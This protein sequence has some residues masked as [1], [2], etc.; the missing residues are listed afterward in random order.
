MQLRTRRKR[1]AHLW[2]TIGGV[3][4]FEQWCQWLTN[5]SW[6][7]KDVA[8]E[9]GHSPSFRI[10]VFGNASTGVKFCKHTLGSCSQ[11]LC[12]Y[13]NRST[14]TKVDTVCA[15]HTQHVGVHQPPPQSKWTLV[16]SP[17]WI[18][19]FSC[20]KRN[21]LWAWTCHWNTKKVLLI[22]H[23]LLIWQGN[24]SGSNG[25]LNIV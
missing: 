17:F 11:L 22:Q 4:E 1:R 16:Y 14:V 9:F 7:L 5:L 21:C 3:L 24:H 23:Q 10:E 13:T 20:S 6:L 12:T 8:P 25:H 15:T 19:R 18:K 2:A